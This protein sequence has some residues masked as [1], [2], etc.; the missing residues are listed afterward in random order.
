MTQH[1][2]K[3]AKN[4][5]STKV[6]NIDTLADRIK[7][8]KRLSLDDRRTFA[9]N[10]GKIAEGMNPEKPLTGAKKVIEASRLNGV[11]EKRKRFFRF[12][13]EDA[14]KASKGSEY[15]V[16]STNFVELAKAAGRLKCTSNRN[17]LLE[18]S[19]QDAVKKMAHGSSFMPTY[20]PE[21]SADISVKNLLDEYSKRLSE[22]IEN[23]T[24]IV[25]LWRA[26][27]TSPINLEV[28][29]DDESE[30]VETSP[31]G[32]AAVF[33]EKLLR[34]LYKAYITNGR[35]EPTRNVMNSNIEWSE[36][37]LKIGVFAVEYDI[38]LFCIPSKNHTLFSIRSVQDEYTDPDDGCGISEWL[39]K[40]GFD[41]KNEELPNLHYG[42]EGLGWK[43]FR[44]SFLHQVGLKVCRGPNNDVEVRLHVWP[45]KRSSSDQF[46]F[47]ADCLV[48]ETSNFDTS[49]LG[50]LMSEELTYTS[51]INAQR[52]VHNLYLPFPDE[53]GHCDQD[54]D[55][56]DYDPL[57]ISLFSDVLEHSKDTETSSGV[58]AIMPNGWQFDPV[59]WGDP[60][61]EE[62]YRGIERAD[63]WIDDLHVSK[64]L[65][66]TKNIR[67][68]PSIQQSE[69]KG[70]AARAGS[71]GSSLLYNASNADEKNR[72]TQLL[73][74]KVQ[75][76]A[77]T[78]LNFVQVL[79]DKDY[80][81]IERI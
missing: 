46:S 56:E 14:P 55:Y 8:E 2:V 15:A 59:H 7:S 36:P 34:P 58:L 29:S 47:L 41:F 66:G 37:T 27:D 28:Y 35:L 50:T 33:P 48:A 69:T 31:Y 42:N 17:D 80:E 45:S 68:Y 24:H 44:V 77:E 81:A 75:H 73:I 57:F 65:L 43:T 60:E 6:G 79:I 4:N 54:N 13:G 1:N 53:T 30:E 32:E 63:A 78:G 74:K 70:G 16:S 26:L 3:I 72:I 51:N 64:L 18:R 76:T 19:S 10:M 67:F 22:A 25:N 23:K 49:A 71:I 20:S 38:R 9:I 39:Y 61:A 12:P 11:L 40:I 62:E 21:H 5:R 52:S